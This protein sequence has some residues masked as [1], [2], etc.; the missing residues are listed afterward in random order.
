MARRAQS[1]DRESKSWNN[2]QRWSWRWYKWWSSY[3]SSAA[4][5]SRQ[6]IKGYSI[7]QRNC[8]QAHWFEIDGTKKG[9]QSHQ[10]GK[11]SNHPAFFSYKLYELEHEMWIWKNLKTLVGFFFTNDHAKTL[12]TQRVNPNWILVWTSKVVS[13]LELSIALISIPNWNRPNGRPNWILVWTSKLDSSLE[14][15]AWL[16]FEMLPFAN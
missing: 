5:T 8:D 12:I 4:V 9:K 6:S 3:V 1:R 15:A 14:M 7:Q 10:P 11:S 13:S 16:H 2:C